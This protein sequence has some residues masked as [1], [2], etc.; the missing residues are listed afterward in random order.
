MKHLA[1]LILVAVALIAQSTLASVFLNKATVTLKPGTAPR[2]FAA[3]TQFKVLEKTRK[4][5]GNIKYKLIYNYS[6]PNTVVFDEIWKSKQDLDLHLQTP[7]MV[8][9][10][11]SI[12]FDPAHYDIKLE[13]GAVIFTPKI[14]NMN[15]VIAKLILEGREKH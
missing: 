13:N 2:Y 14:G 1:N 6:Q 12:N 5:P 15:Y 11:Q 3:A 10:F 9:F 7:H 8:A 4:E